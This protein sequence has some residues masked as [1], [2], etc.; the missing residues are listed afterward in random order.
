VRFECRKCHT[1]WEFKLQGQLARL[2]RELSQREQALLA[3]EATLRLREDRHR[4]EVQLIRSC[5]HPD[6][7]PGDASGRFHRAFQAFNRMLEAPAAT[8]DDDDIP[9]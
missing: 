5:L 8:I 3:R 4:K 7:H 9:F 2:D 1:V 6:K